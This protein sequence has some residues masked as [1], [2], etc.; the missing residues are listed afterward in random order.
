MLNPGG[1]LVYS[2]CTYNPKENESVVQFLL[3]NR[4][5]MIQPVALDLP[6]NPGLNR[7]K[8]KTYEPSITQCW[9]IYPHQLDTVGFFLARVVKGS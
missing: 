5:A 9:R 1:T 8:E 3:E 6:H 7:W 2:T 4:E